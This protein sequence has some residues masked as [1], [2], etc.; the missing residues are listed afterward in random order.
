MS[1]RCVAC[2]KTRGKDY[3]DPSWREEYSVD[4]DSDK[5]GDGCQNRAEEE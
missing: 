3:L 1:V 4:I 2:E 5:G